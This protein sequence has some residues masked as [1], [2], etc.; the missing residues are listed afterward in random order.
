LWAP[1]D[2]YLVSEDLDRRS[3][4][5]SSCQLGFEQHQERDAEGSEAG[6]HIDD[7]G[8]V[9]AFHRVLMTYLDFAQLC[10][11]ETSEE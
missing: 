5:R 3:F 7:I 6:S 8:A 2:R 4:D 1:V 11:A 10:A 9:D